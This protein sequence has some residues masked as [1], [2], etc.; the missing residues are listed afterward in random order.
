[1]KNHI[2]PAIAHLPVTALKR[3]PPDSALYRYTRFA[4]FLQA[5]GLTV[6]PYSMNILRHLRAT[7]VMQALGM[8]LL[9]A[10]SK[11]NEKAVVTDG[12]LAA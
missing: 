1:M 4:G 11:T 10:K 12:G 6:K 9:P 2:F 3:S 5:S 8:L 7:A